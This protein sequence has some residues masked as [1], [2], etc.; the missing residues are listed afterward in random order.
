MSVLLTPSPQVFIGIEN[1]PSDLS[2]LQAEQS[3][4]SQPFLVEEMLQSLHYLWW[5]LAGRFPVCRRLSCTEEPRTGHSAPG[6]S[7]SVLSGGEGSQLAF[8]VTRAHDWLCHQFVVYQD[9]D[10]PSY[11][12]ACQSVRPNFFF[13]M[14]LLFFRC[15]MLH[16]PLLNFLS[17]NALCAFLA[18]FNS[19]LKE[20]LSI[21]TSDKGK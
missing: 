5:P 10:V 8:F 3:Q 14:G 12:A 2:L 18:I 16:F 19:S 21:H 17:H 7:S 6:V 13:Y 4:L 9:P 11:R 1:I 20:S 15:R